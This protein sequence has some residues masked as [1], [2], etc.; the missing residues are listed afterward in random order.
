MTAGTCTEQLRNVLLGLVGEQ[1]SDGLSVMD[2]GGFPES[3]FHGVGFSRAKFTGQVPTCQRSVRISLPCG[4]DLCGCHEQNLLTTCHH[5]GHSS[6]PSHHYISP[7]FC[8]SF[9]FLVLLPFI[10]LV[11]QQPE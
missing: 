4:L 5:L 10:R 6:V 2:L 3:R 1:E 11:A 9:P 8:N 7:D